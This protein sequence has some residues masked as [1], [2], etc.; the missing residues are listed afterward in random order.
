MCVEYNRRRSR[1]EGA[2][3]SNEEAGFHVTASDVDDG[4]F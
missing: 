3:V 4:L 2:S 1:R